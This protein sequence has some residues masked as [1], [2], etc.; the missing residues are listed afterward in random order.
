[1]RFEGRTQSRISSSFT[2][3]W[4]QVRV[5][6]VFVLVRKPVTMSE[7]LAPDKRHG[8]IHNGKHTISS[9]QA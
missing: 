2:R 4:S 1:M 5:G 6:S 9:V 8:F 7:N 3:I